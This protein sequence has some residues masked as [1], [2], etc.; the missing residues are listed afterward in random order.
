MANQPILLAEDVLTALARIPPGTI[1]LCIAD[2][3][4][5]VKTDIAAARK[6][7]RLKFT[8]E[9]DGLDWYREGDPR[10]REEQ[11]GFLTKWM[12][13]VER[14]LR[15][16]GHAV[17]WYDAQRITHV[18]EAV[19]NWPKV[20]LRQNLIWVKPYPVPR[21]GGVN[22]MRGEELAAWVTKDDPDD[23]AET[24]FSPG[25]EIAAWVTKETASKR[26]AVFNHTLGQCSNVFICPQVRGRAR[27][28]PAQKPEALI[29]TL[30]SYLSSPG[31]LVLD[32]FAGSFTTTRVALETGRQPVAVER[33]T[34]CWDAALPGAV[35][36]VPESWM[37]AARAP[38]PKRLGFL[39][40]CGGRLVGVDGEGLTCDLCG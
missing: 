19:K 35:P 16:G 12:T 37:P 23:H 11:R 13:E 30:I 32:L 4:W 21:G 22:F 1:S 40:H 36:Y 20:V 34:R 24:T 26:L 2:P 38:E 33:D 14:V 6:R 29:E 15:P 5:G 10:S 25:A 31:E 8:V 39:H 3:D 27:I 7:N 17:V 28:H 18:Y 9:Q